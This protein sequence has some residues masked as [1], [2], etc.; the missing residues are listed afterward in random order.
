MGRD[1]EIGRA[2]TKDN[3][4]IDYCIVSSNVFPIITEFEVFPF[5]PLLS[6]VHCLIHIK[7]DFLFV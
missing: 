4:L 1:K 5:D 3:R 6:D 7:M 2:T